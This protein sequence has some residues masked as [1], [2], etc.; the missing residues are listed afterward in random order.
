MKQGTGPYG[1]PTGSAVQIRMTGSATMTYS[2]TG[3]TFTDL[4]N[5]AFAAL[6]F[7]AGLSGLAFTGSADG[8][9]QSNTIGTSGS[10][11]SGSLKN[12]MQL[13]L[14]G[15]GAQ[16]A[17]VL[18]NA[19]FGYGD[20]A[21]KATVFGSGASISPKLDLT[22]GRNT[23]KDVRASATFTVGFYLDVGL[24]SS[25]APTACVNFGQGSG[26][27][28]VMDASGSTD[29]NTPFL[30]LSNTTDNNGF[31]KFLNYSG[32]PDVGGT[33]ADGKIN[34]VVRAGITSSSFDGFV[35]SSEAANVGS[36]SAAIGRTCNLPSM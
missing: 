14:R 12:N 6:D 28:N 18:D 29:A 9:I 23:I 25:D 30:V 19:L 13:E 2:I 16:R 1:A 36:S 3:N 11:T 17:R 34:T 20:H 33:T 31:L 24:G 26:N 4:Q 35:D 32:G 22:F 8:L 21:F 15:S 5:A 27:S 10:T 7:T